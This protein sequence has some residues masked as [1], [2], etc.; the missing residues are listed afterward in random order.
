[1][2]GF[3]LEGLEQSAAA[4]FPV[5]RGFVG[6]LA[7]GEDGGDSKGLELCPLCE[8]DALKALEKDLGGSI[9]TGDA[10]A[11]EAESGD[12]AKAGFGGIFGHGEGEEAVGF[13][14][15]LKHFPETRFEDP[16]RQEAPWK[17]GRSL[18]HH[19]GNVGGERG[20]R[21]HGKRTCF[22][23]DVCQPHGTPLVV[24]ACSVSRSR[25]MRFCVLL[26]ALLG[27]CSGLLMGAG[28]EKFQV[29]GRPVSL[30]VPD[31]AAAGRPW[32]WVG[33]FGG[34]L[35]A[36]EE[37]LV[38]RG[39]HVA[40]VGVSNQFGSEGAM[41]VWEKL[42][43]ELCG[44][45]GLSARPALLGISRGGLYVNAW[46]RR[47]PDRVSVLYLDNAV[48]DV[49][50]WP[51]GMAL[52]HQGRGSPKDWGLYK[53]EFGFGSDEEAVE[54]SIRPTDGLKA[55]VQAG[56]FLLS[57]HGTADRVVPYEDNA[58]ELVKFWGQQGGRV[59][60]FPKEGGDHHPHG[61]PDSTPLVE[62]L[63]REAVGK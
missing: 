20:F 31:Q 19:D 2:E 16:E 26:L 14:G 54:K 27:G 40:Y 53:A 6:L 61:L 34:H 17:E 58:W 36:L 22:G 57:V 1:L 51:G 46:T 43:A 9:G 5:L 63:I 8:A 3:V 60:L 62:V 7:V 48:C 47:H 28:V 50:S 10:H 35:K 41:A 25:V 55:A 24:L 49:R 29:E 15:G 52:K 18:D 13:E 44:K 37:S 21:D 45:R 4:L 23:A 30:K 32:L 38:E 42:Y 12:W 56:V 33:E 39:W 59:Q 11:D